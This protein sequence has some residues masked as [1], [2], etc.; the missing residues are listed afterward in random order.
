MINIYWLQNIFEHLGTVA[1]VLVPDK[2]VVFAHQVLVA[3]IIIF[4]EHQSAWEKI[5]CV[6]LIIVSEEGVFVD[7]VNVLNALV[8]FFRTG[9]LCWC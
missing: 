3:P 7:L 2:W 6:F 5:L 9:L 4:G 8:E 1:I